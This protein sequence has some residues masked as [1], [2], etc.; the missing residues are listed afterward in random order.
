MKTRQDYINESNR[1]I[2]NVIQN[3][4]NREIKIMN[5]INN[6]DN[7]EKSK[8]KNNEIVGLKKVQIIKKIE[9]DNDG[10]ILSPAII[11]I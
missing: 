6:A 7:K 1:I 2:E 4:K 9:Y 10:N 11:V 5:S 8:D 3:H